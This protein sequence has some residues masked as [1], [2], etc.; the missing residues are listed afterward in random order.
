MNKSEKRKFEDDTLFVGKEEIKEEQQAVT[1]EEEFGFE[2][3]D[4][5]EM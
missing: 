1:G 2:E 4:V 3:D 5:D